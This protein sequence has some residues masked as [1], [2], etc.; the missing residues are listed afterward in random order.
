MK[1][2]ILTV[3][4]PA[5][6]K[7]TWAK[8][9]VL[10]SGGKMKRV[11]RDSLRL[12]LDE[13]KTSVDNE[14]EIGRV[15]YA[16]VRQLLNDGYDVIIDDTNLNSKRFHDFCKVAELV[17][18][19]MVIEQHFDIQSKNALIN[20]DASREAS[21]GKAVINEMWDKWVAYQKNAPYYAENISSKRIEFAKKYVHINKSNMEDAIMLDVDGTLALFDTRNPYDMEA[22][23][24]DYP[25]IPL[26]DILGQ[27]S[28]DIK[29]IIMTGRNADHRKNLEIWL[30]SNGIHYDEIYMR[31]SEMPTEKD[32]YIKELLYDTH[33]LGKY[34][35]IAAF[36]DR[37][38][39][40]D[41]WRKL[42]IPTYQVFYGDF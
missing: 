27:F 2:L 15:Q 13:N 18:D 9:Q 24:D 31:P 14:K 38:Q 17:G 39:A 12:M 21:V 16:M 1:R 19:C 28:P 4:P 37:N 20:R 5:I 8:E 29:R 7:S 22:A 23:L 30:Q 3:G 6:G 41:L 40:V 25:N 42:G 33:I 36:D 11:N 10:N 32:D 26:L 35:I 34:N